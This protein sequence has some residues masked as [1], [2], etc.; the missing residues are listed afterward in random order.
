MKRLVVTTAAIALIVSCTATTHKAARLQVYTE[1]DE[2]TD[3]A[4]WKSFR[5]TSAQTSDSD[6]TRFPVYER[7]VRSALVQEL[8]DRGYVQTQYG[9]TD[10][11]VAFE[12]VFRGASA[13]GSFE[14]THGVNTDPNMSRGTT[15]TSTLIVRMLDPTTSNVLWQ[16]RLSGF[17]VDSV[18]PEASFKKAVWRVLVEFPPITG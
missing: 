2:T 16:G 11:R 17:D 7:M 18:G 13:P 10:F 5:L 3:F 12:L 6:Y 1:H 9:E 4:A 8:T 15:S 14:D